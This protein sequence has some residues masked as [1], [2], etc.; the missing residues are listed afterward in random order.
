[1]VSSVMVRAT[2]TMPD[3]QAWVTLRRKRDSRRHDRDR[4][5]VVALAPD[6]L[7][8]S[9]AEPR[10]ASHVLEKLPYTGDIRVGALRVAHGSVTHDVVTDDHR[11]GARDLDG[12]FE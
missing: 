3:R 8:R 11:P 10:V 5:P 1:M 4:K 12:K 9:R 7:Q 6:R 2:A